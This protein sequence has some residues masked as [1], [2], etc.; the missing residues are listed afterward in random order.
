M[1]WF[2]EFKNMRIVNIG[3]NNIEVI[4]EK[5]DLP[6]LEFLNLEKN[7]L[8]SLNFLGNCKNLREIF[9]A[10][11]KIKAIANLITLREL[12]LLDVSNN[13]IENFDDMAMLSFNSKLRNLSL[14]G[15]P[16]E[17]KRNF[18]ENLKKLFPILK[19]GSLFFDKNSKYQKYSDIAF[20]QNAENR[21]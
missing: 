16:I 1:K 15:N 8:K 3:G 6:N 21:F 14:R 4:P 19:E 10:K 11:N 9:A 13:C 7:N 5:L 2:V 17:L 12:V 18:K 20:K